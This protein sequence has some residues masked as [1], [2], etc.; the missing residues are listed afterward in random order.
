MDDDAEVR[1]EALRWMTSALS[2]LDRAIETGQTAT[3]REL[4][5][6]LRDVLD[7][8]HDAPEDAAPMQ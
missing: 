8:L 7:T 2:D 5:R 6:R 1:L 4:L 3:A